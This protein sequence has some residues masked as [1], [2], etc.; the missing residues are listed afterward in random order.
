MNPAETAPSSQTTAVA[1]VAACPLTSLPP[2]VSD[3]VRAIRTG[4]PF[5]FPRHDGGVFGNRERHLPEAAKGY[6]H[7]Y[8]VITPGARD[9]STRRIITG[10]TPVTD[11]RQYFYTSN[12]YES[13]CL[14][15]GAGGQ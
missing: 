8:T 15:T 13:F 6:Y 10:G 7:E 9:R 12:H 1:G 3:T 4:G 2:Q 5:P 11:P 14:V